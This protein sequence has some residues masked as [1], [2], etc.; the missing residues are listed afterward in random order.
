MSSN[1]YQLKVKEVV[2]ETQDAVSVIFENPNAGAITYK[3]GQFLTLIFDIEGESVRRAYSLCSAPGIDANPAVTV[4]RVE[5]GKVSNHINDNIK[6]GDTIEVMAPAGVFTTEITKKNKRHVVLFAGGSG[7][8]PMMSLMQSI[9]NTESSSIVSLV[10]AN[11]D[12]NSIIFKKKIEDLKAK[13]GKQLNIVHVLENPPA[14]WDGHKGMLNPDLV[15]TILKSLPKK[16]FKPREYFMCGPGGMMEQIELAFTKYK[17]PQDKLRKESFGVSLEDAQK[18]AGNEVEG[19]VERV[20]T[21]KYSGEEHKVTV[22][23]KESILDAALDDNIDLP[24]S[25]QSGICTSCLGRCTSGKVYM[26]EEDA[27]SA[28]EIEQGFVLTCVGHPLTDDVVI[29]VD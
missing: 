29:E 17:L 6:A 5:G 28:K 11:R 12:E 8:T 21:I 4:K 27:L 22:E 14:G 24:F 16:L 19:I 15:Q 2:N 10:Y 7:I 9:L 18:G 13:Y 23:P 1:N 25:C 26:E 20:V 3:S